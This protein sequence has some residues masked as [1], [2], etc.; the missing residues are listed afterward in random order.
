[1]QEI[2]AEPYWPG[3]WRM[4]QSLHPK[5]RKEFVDSIG[6]DELEKIRL[7]A[8]HVE[9]QERAAKEIKG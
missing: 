2:N 3:V 4:I 7:A 5:A 8:E 1:M 6:E 9:A